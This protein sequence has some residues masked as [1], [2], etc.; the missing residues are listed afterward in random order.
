MFSK[1]ESQQ[2]ELAASDGGVGGENN[3]LTSS[4][5]SG[6]NLAALFVFYTYCT[7]AEMT[8]FATNSLTTL[9]SCMHDCVS[10]KYDVFF[11]PLKN[12]NMIFN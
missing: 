3:K 12:I 5:G 11:R 1:G 7:N 10:V 4:L 9:D 8:K 2:I 6:T